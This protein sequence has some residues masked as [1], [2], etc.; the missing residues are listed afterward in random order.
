MKR[1]SITASIALSMLL[2]SVLSS[3]LPKLNNLEWQGATL[4]RLPLFG[5]QSDDSEIN[6]EWP[7]AEDFASI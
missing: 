7:T 4:K 2:N 5:K 6:F 1:I 3:V